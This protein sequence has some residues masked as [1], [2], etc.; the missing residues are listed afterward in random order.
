M[1]TPSISEA[2][3]NPGEPKGE[4]TPSPLPDA[5]D[6]HPRG[7]RQR[8]LHDPVAQLAQMIEQRHPPLEVRSPLG[9]Y[10][11]LAHDARVLGGTGKLRHDRI[12]QKPNLAGLLGPWGSAAEPGPTGVSVAA[13]RW[14][15]R[16]CCCSA[17][18]WLCWS[19]GA[20]APW[21]LW[22]GAAVRCACGN[23]SAD[24]PS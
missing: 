8:H 14:R 16:I 17:S 7:Q 2:N 20:V 24:V 5:G 12:Q 22:D 21:A 11:P 23:W 13:D 19:A 9:A 18:I 6:L 1:L 4:P 10:V 15:S 3:Q